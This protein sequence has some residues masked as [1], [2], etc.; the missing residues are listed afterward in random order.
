MKLF[1]VIITTLLF[2][3]TTFLWLSPAI[4]TQDTAV[5]LIERYQRALSI[6]SNNP[7]LQ[8]QLGVA[9]LVEN[10]PYE[11][12]KKF[13]LAYP[14][15][16]DSV[17]M[18]YNLGLAYFKIDDPDSA[19]LYF[20]QSEELGALDQPERY[21]LED[22]YFNL[23]LTYLNNNLH[24]EAEQIF[25]KVLSLNPDLIKV[26][27]ALGKLYTLSGQTKD[28]VREYE[29]YLTAQPNDQ[30]VRDFL[31]ATYYNNGLKK[32]SLNDHGEAREYFTKALT[33]SPNNPHVRSTLAHTDL[34]QGN[35]EAAIDKLSILD[36]QADAEL[37]QNIRVVIFN[38]ALALLQRK[39]DSDLAR[40]EQ[41]VRTL[42]KAAPKD[43][44]TLFLAGNIA[45]N[46]KH[47][48]QA[49]K[50][51]E[52]LLDIDP[53]HEGAL[54]NLSIARKGAVKELVTKGKGHFQDGEY[55]DASSA[56]ELALSIDPTVPGA[57][58]LASQ[59]RSELKRQASDLFNKAEQALSTGNAQRALK[60]IRKGRSNQPDNQ[61]GAELETKAFGLLHAE[62]KD[63]LSS[64]NSSLQQDKLDLA[65]IAF[66]RVLE[67]DSKNSSALAGI[68]H[69][70]E[71]NKALAEAT[72]EKA[73][74]SFANG[75]L[76]AAQVAYRKALSLQPENSDAAA[77]LMKTLSQIDT[78]VASALRQSER[79]GRAGN[80][81]TARLQLKKALKLRDTPEIHQKLTALDTEQSKQAKQLLSD[82][83]KLIHAEDFNSAEKLYI[84]ILQHDPNHAGAHEGLT[85]VKLSRSGAIS[86]DLQKAEAALNKKDVGTTLENYRK[87]LLLEPANTVALAGIK[88]GKRLAALSLSQLKADANR[89]LKENRFSAAESGYRKVLELDP[90]HAE[91]IEALERIDKTRQSDVQE[92]DQQQLY[93]TGIQ[94]YTKGQ[95][96]DAIDSWQKVLLLDPDHEK[97][98]M[99]IKKSRR[100]L[101]MIEE[102]KQ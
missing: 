65:R 45:L 32:L 55:L 92:G 29:V 12:I 50:N 38:S 44:K 30:P 68:A 19:V 90:Y 3:T 43:I 67:I 24:V 28:A 79:A 77:G 100:K 47:Y 56:F 94:L 86:R 26:H 13:R 88:Q 63:N 83:D 91:A 15:Y 11:A 74:V 53:G 35:P 42:L 61:R 6:D 21:P 59:A 33:L 9:L 39:E 93:L 14:A 2:I 54:L 27:H 37:Q 34:L 75:E 69:I 58:D 41:A 64:G 36:P 46:Q 40:A 17:E 10:K 101:R 49:R 5:S 20:E 73:D 70:D 62:I 71:Q 23:G 99:N 95:Y 4:A 80:F 7:T 97:A 66:T 52:T 16:I 1:P 8:Y 98:Q 78:T 82:A 87:V 22:A 18:N 57:S 89:A 84:R 76:H 81:H 31:F 102:R 25:L 85:E 51:Y 48:D 60:H 72:I 96:N